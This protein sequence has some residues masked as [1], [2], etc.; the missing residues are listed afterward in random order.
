MLNRLSFVLLASI[1]FL[2]GSSGNTL[3]D[4]RPPNVVVIFIHDMGYADIGPFGATDYQTPNLDLMANEGMRFTD[5]VVSSAVC[6]ASRAALLTGSYHL[7]VGITGALGPGS[8]IGINESETTLAELCKSKGYA[9]ACFGK[10]H[11]GHH[12]K[13]LPTQHGFDEYF[14]L[15]YSN[16]MWP[17]HPA[18]LER[19]AKNPDAKPIYP[20]LPLLRERPALPYL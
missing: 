2:N 15:P 10:W 12:P 18:N 16:D 8:Q 17:Y 19:L 3:G 4:D 14:G 6:S 1:A 9:T 7:R 11:L 5:F 20:P 13:F